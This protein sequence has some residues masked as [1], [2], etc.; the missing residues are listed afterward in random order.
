M[1]YCRSE[2]ARRA[3]IDPG[4]FEGMSDDNLLGIARQSLYRQGIKYR[5]YVVFSVL[6]KDGLT[7]ART[8]GFL[9]MVFVLS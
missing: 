3:G 2:G 4:Q 9:G 5:S 1:D 7:Q 8:I 6:T